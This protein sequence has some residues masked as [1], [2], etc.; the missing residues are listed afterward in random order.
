[1][2]LKGKGPCSICDN[3]EKR[4]VNIC[5]T[6]RMHVQ[7]QILRTCLKRALFP[8][9]EPRGLSGK[10]W[11][12]PIFGRGAAWSPKLRLC[13]TRWVLWPPDSSNPCLPKIVIMTGYN[14]R[15]KS[16]M[17]DFISAFERRINFY[18]PF[19]YSNRLL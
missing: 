8:S 3:Y 18:T 5:L 10:I 13:S 2:L 15:S 4:D 7:K 14:E 1:M 6:S 16:R 11:W 19:S 9:L 17:S 12:G